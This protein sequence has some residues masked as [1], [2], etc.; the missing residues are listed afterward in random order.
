M[1]YIQWIRWLGSHLKIGRANGRTPRGCRSRWPRTMPAPVSCSGLAARKFVQMPSATG[2]NNWRVEGSK[3]AAEVA[4]AG[5]RWRCG[6]T[7]AVGR[8][9]AIWRSLAYVPLVGGPRCGNRRTRA[10]APRCS[11]RCK[12]LPNLGHVCVVADSPTK[13]RW[14][15]GLGF[16]SV[17]SFSDRFGLPRSVCVGPFN[18]PLGHIYWFR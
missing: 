15:T 14:A 1:L 12:P 13:M 5:C 17:R 10:D 16:S 2:Q 4:A 11:R 18:M 9:K 3:R 6:D 8:G 7:A